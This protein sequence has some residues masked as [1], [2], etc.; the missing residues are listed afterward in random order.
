MNGRIIR[1][2]SLALIV[3]ASA[4]CFA[5]SGDDPILTAMRHEMERSTGKLKLADAAAPYYMS[6]EITD[7]DTQ[8]ASAALGAMRTN[9]RI[10]MR[11]LR[12]IVRVGSYKQDSF[13]QQGVGVSDSVPLGDDEIALRHSIWLA[14]DRAYKEATEALTSKQARLKQLNADE[15][16]FDDFAHAEPVH[17]LGPVARIDYND[18]Q[19]TDILKSSSALARLDPQL[20]NTA[21]DLEFSAYNRYFVNSEGTETRSGQA[22]YQLRINGTTQ[23]ADGMRLDRNYPVAVSSA[24]ELPN[25]AAFLDL[26]TQVFSALKALRNA[27]L[28]EEDY[29]GPVMMSGDASATIFA[30]LVGENVLGSRPQLGESGRTRGAFSSNYKSR[31]LPDFLDI[32]DDPTRAAVNGHSLMGAYEVD[33]E[34]VK[35]AKVPLVQKGILTSYLV[36]RNPIRDFPVSNG[37]GR[38]R[39][40]SSPGVS[41]GNLII[42]SNDPM[43]RDQLKKKLLERCKERGLAYGY[44]A[45]TLGPQRA[46]RML[47]KVYVSDGHEELVRGAAFGDLDTRSLRS[48]LIA[49]ADDSYIDNRPTMVPHSIVSPSTLFEELEVKRA[50]K[51]K[52][53]LPEYPPPTI[54]AK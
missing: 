41:L 11:M 15:N 50:H 37:H 45:D 48:D 18:A 34:G 10:H 49:A 23:A 54:A 30:D 16:D 28:V 38:A 46:P 7:I 14:A 1:S 32:V 2:L 22:I 20:E 8:A 40:G 53:K 9:A 31:V 6:F 24:A 35:A 42:T 3:F 17:Y 51:Q 5:Q 4:L 47:Y 33:Q 52:D 13:Y 36:G 26:T 21:T 44:F 27:P 12:V 19:W 43:T 39:I 25:K 29:R